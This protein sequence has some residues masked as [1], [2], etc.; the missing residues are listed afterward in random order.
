M[1]GSKKIV[2]VGA[3]QVARTVA[4][5][6][7][8]SWDV[9]LVD[10]HEPTL[11]AFPERA[12]GALI[13]VLGDG[14]S[15]LVL[16]RAGLDRG[17]VLVACTRSD[18][19]NKECARLA[20]QDFGVEERVVLLDIPEGL[21]AAGLLRG[22][23]V[24]R[25]VATAARVLNALP[26]G[27]SRATT[28]GLGEGELLQV[29]VLEGSGAIGR[30]L[31]TLHARDWLVAAI[32][33]DA[34]LIVPHGKTA[35]QAGDRV[36]LVGEPGELAL[37][38]AWFRGGEPTF[39][40]V[41]GQNVGWVG[42]S[43]EKLACWLADRSKASRALVLPAALLD[44]GQLAPE[45]ALR[46]VTEA[47]VGVL[48]VPPVPVPLLARLGLILPFR[49]LRL[50]SFGRPL[51]VA[52]SDRPV[53]RVLL[54]VGPRQDPRAAAGVAI[55]L[56]RELGATLTCLVVLAPA[57]AGQ[58]DRDTQVP[59]QVAR[60]AQLHDVPLERRLDEGNP[61]ERIRH[62]ARDFDLLVIGTSPPRG[63]SPWNPDV[64][65]YLMHDAPC[66]VLLVPRS[67]E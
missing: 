46:A 4:A 43:S 63:V 31:Q 29:S 40:T 28:L 42:A 19:A 22:E 12:A 62:H 38:A 54:A 51:L 60:L 61:V 8:A 26:L 36:L 66:S 49:A 21:E 24:A 65:L 32:Y 48:V 25:H 23:V 67:R 45:E 1:Q 37:V 20:R 57:V 33:R 34:R 39:P 30:E 6:L 55:D 56:A 9:V 27:A 17:A 58:D 64:S 47:D 10:L 2:F 52:R 18:E 44:Q 16:A 13:R 14:T 5:G 59:R 7:P 50:L 11:F 53:T 3:G 41:Y 35:V 15:R